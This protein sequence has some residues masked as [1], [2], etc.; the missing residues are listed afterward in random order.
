MLA[1][2]TRQQPIG[3]A[4]VAGRVLV[5]GVKGFDQEHPLAVAGCPARLHLFF[6]QEPTEGFFR[7][8]GIERA[9][10]DFVVVVARGVVVDGAAGL[11]VFPVTRIELFR[12]C[13]VP[14]PDG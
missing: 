8:G 4:V 6:E 9:G 2:F 14:S 1:E 7:L 5:I 13:Y 10:Q 3:A 11:L 12:A